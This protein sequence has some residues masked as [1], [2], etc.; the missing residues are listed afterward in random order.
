MGKGGVGGGCVDGA[1]GGL[2]GCC[3]EREMRG[4]GPGTARRRGEWKCPAGIGAGEQREEG[5][6]PVRRVAEW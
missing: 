5:C 2:G 3:V 1:R 6:E 4:V